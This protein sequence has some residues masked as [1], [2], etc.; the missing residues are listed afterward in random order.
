MY[1]VASTPKIHFIVWLPG[2]FDSGVCWRGS[3]KMPTKLCWQNTRKKISFPCW[4]FA[5]LLSLSFYVKCV[6]YI[7][8]NTYDIF[9]RDDWKRDWTGRNRRKIRLFDFCVAEVEIE[10]ARNDFWLDLGWLH[11]G[12]FMNYLLI[13][14]FDIFYDFFR[15]KKIHLK[16][17]KK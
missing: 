3:K 13:I 11:R 12:N 5:S 4:L 17:I 10:E 1:V 6:F 8:S 14:F 9:W 15:N 7:R 2:K 16:F